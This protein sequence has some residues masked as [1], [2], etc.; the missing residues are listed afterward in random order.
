LLTLGSLLAAAAF[1]PYFIQVLWLAFFNANGLLWVTHLNE[2][3]R[4]RLAE[5]ERRFS[6]GHALEEKGRFAEAVEF[7]E[8]LPKDFADYPKFGE[9]CASRVAYLRR[10]HPQVFGARK[11]RRRSASKARPK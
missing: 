5:F 3:G 6:D 7:Y 11:S 10:E 1:P 2:R 8:S 9:I 4:K